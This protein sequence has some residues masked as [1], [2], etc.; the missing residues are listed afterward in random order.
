MD[1]NMCSARTSLISSVDSCYTTDSANFAR[2]L[3]AATETMSGGSLSGEE[4]RSLFINQSYVA[5]YQASQT[6]CVNG[7][8]GLLPISSQ[9]IVILILKL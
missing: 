5:L 1:G 6:H 2:L 9:W 7:R 3:A 8:A 4:R